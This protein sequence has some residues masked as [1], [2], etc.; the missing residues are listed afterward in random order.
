[1]S[2]RTVD[3]F[4]HSFKND[5]TNNEMLHPTIIKSQDHVVV[6]FCNQK[7]IKDKEKRLVTGQS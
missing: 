1:M 7:S 4:E 2:I 6:E 5:V 3:P